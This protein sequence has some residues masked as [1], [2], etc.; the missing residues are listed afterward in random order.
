VLP[1][2]SSITTLRPPPGW[3]GGGGHHSLLS[4]LTTDWKTIGCHLGKL[5][6]GKSALE[7][8][9]MLI[10]AHWVHQEKVLSTPLITLRYASLLNPRHQSNRHSARHYS[11][12]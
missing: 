10:G 6:P 11:L 2:S 8:G 7:S 1:L 9:L 4:C 12:E 5:P 3:D